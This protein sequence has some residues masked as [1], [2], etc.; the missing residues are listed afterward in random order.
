VPVVIRAATIAALALSISAPAMAD[1]TTVPTSYNV[2]V[3]CHSALAGYADHD[4]ESCVIEESLAD[5]RLMFRMNWDNI[6]ARYRRDCIAS[7][8]S[9]DQAFYLRSIESCIIDRETFGK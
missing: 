3:A 4:V 5:F 7:A 2:A 8:A 9:G 6:P 1:D